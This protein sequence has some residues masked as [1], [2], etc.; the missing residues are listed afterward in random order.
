MKKFFLL[1]MSCVFTS[2]IFFS[3][4]QSVKDAFNNFKRTY[5]D[6]VKDCVSS[7]KTDEI[8]NNFIVEDQ[9][10]K[11]NLDKQ[12]NIQYKKMIV[13]AA[14]FVQ[15]FQ[16]GCDI[17]ET[18]LEFEK[19]SNDMTLVGYGNGS[20]E[21]NERCKQKV[22][23][24]MDWM[25][26]ECS[27]KSVKSERKEAIDKTNNTFNKTDTNKM[28]DVPPPPELKCTIDFTPPKVEESSNSNNQENTEEQLQSVYDLLNKR[29]G[30]TDSGI[31]W[32]DIY[33]AIY[34]TEAGDDETAI[35]WNKIDADVSKQLRMGEKSTEIFIKYIESRPDFDHKWAD[36]VKGFDNDDTLNKNQKSEDER[37]KQL[38]DF[39]PMQYNGYKDFSQTV[40]ADEFVK[41][42]TI[43]EKNIKTNADHLFVG[44]YNMLLRRVA[45]YLQAYVY[46]YDVTNA[47]NCIDIRWSD[48]Q[49]SAQF[50]SYDCKKDFDV[51]LKQS[52]DKAN[53][54][55]QTKR[56]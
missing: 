10:V 35:M 2:I 41:K 11:T 17:T 23:E 55:K 40:Y 53:Q 31:K 44:N 43:D 13:I 18:R 28:V 1:L 26:K 46:D 50:I 16:G 27:Q 32:L 51:K 48:T 30:K 54:V 22:K 49:N 20:K 15:K 6:D 38:K 36:S 52:Q 56:L 39:K 3:C 14:T 25:E 7:R 12:L 4:T 34:E 37:K 42:Y 29:Y 9:Y 5:F 45:D 19:L 47:L 8:I 21:F 33:A 24:L